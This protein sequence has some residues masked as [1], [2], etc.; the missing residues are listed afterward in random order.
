MVLKTTTIGPTMGVQTPTPIYNRLLPVWKN[1]R[2]ATIG[3]SAVKSG[4]YAKQYLPCPPHYEGGWYNSILHR[5][6]WFGATGLT[7]ES[8]QGVIFRRDPVIEPEP[9]ELIEAQL[10][11]IDPDANSLR[12]LVTDVVQDIIQT[13][14]GGLLVEYDDTNNIVMTQEQANRL[15]LRA[16]LVYYPAES[17]FH[18]RKNHIRLWEQYVESEDEFDSE[19]KIQIKVLDLVTSAN[20]GQPIYRQRIF[21]KIESQDSDES[22]W[23]QFGDDIFPLLPGGRNMDFIPFEYIGSKNNSHVPD[24]PMLEGLVNANFQHYGLYSDFRE[25]VYWIRP[26]PYTSGYTNEPGKKRVVNSNIWMD[27]PDPETKVGILEFTGSGLEYDVAALSMLEQQMAAMGADI[28]RVRKRSAESADKARIDK[29]SETS[30][31]ATMVNNISSAFTKSINTMLMWNGFESNFTY[32]INTDYDPS[33]FDAQMLTAINQS[34]E[35]RNLSRRSAINNFKNSELLPDGV[36]VQDE[37][38]QINAETLG[39]TGIEDLNELVRNIVNSMSD[40]TN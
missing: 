37:I 1:I 34:V 17:I 31:L 26:L 6:Y 7:V 23:R 22:E 20:T 14:Y 18:A 13:G 24:T 4:E 19:T 16:R 35:M 15:G 27:F 21:R 10:N 3:Q 2:V 40:E 30:V 38:D 8:Y 5:A 12:T 11:D 32:Q 36:T 28:L 25:A 39:T 33:M 9:T 29:S